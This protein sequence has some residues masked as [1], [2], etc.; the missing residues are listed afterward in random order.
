MA[1]SPSSTRLIIAIFA[2]F[3]IAVLFWVA[4]LSPKRKEADELATK[5]ETA[6]SS[7]A[8]AQSQV[9]DGESAR[10]EFPKNYRKLIVLGKAVPADG[11]TA[12]LLVQMSHV[13]RESKLSFEAIK[14]GAAAG[15]AATTEPAPPVEESGAETTTV[16]AAAAT[17]A[18]ASALPLGASVGTAGLNVMPYNLY[19]QGSFFDVADFIHGIDGFVHTEDPHLTVDGRLMTIDGFSL[20]PNTEVGWPVLEANF[21]VTTY[22]VPPG[23]GLTAGASPTGPG[24]VEEV[25][26][27]PVSSTE[28]AQ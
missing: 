20:V 26:S 9:A 22:L 4:V 25:S 18:A 7:L 11:E 5:V 8:A 23:Q 14:L 28:G 16:P 12:S 10:R 17:E 6:Q 2:V 19:F 1:A 13:S 27:E 24:E 15:E 21:S 3:G